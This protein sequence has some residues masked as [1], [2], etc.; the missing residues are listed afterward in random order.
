MGRDSRFRINLNR[1]KYFNWESK[2]KVKIVL[3]AL[4]IFGIIFGFN[5]LQNTVN[6]NKTKI[7]PIADASINEEIRAEIEKGQ[8]DI[9]LDVASE[10]ID[11][12]NEKTVEELG[13]IDLEGKTSNDSKT[14]EE[15][16]KKVDS[17]KEETKIAVDTT[18]AEEKEEVKETKEN[19]L[20][21]E[22]KEE[23]VTKEETENVETA[24]AEEKSKAPIYSNR[25]I[26]KDNVD[27]TVLGEIMMGAEVSENLNYAY[28]MAFKTIY[29]YTREADFTYAALATNIASTDKLQNLTSKYLV[30]K[31]IRLAFSE[32]GID[33]IN[34]ATDHITDYDK[35][36]FSTTIDTLKRNQIYMTGIND[37][38]LYVDVCRKENSN[39]S[40]T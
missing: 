29:T 21:G 34:I 5:V 37:S 1:R 24:K 22:S 3:G 8:V 9:Y 35:I 13:L 2:T 33:A 30:T 20:E 26:K 17:S 31:E 40:C 36:F 25:N 18:N 38:T 4:G 19:T 11:S 14:N 39:Y 27:F 10:S 12:K 23:V 32:L 28:N 7:I 15:S 6:F 16:S